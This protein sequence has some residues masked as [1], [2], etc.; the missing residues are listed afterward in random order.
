[1]TS[2]W[3]SDT[4][5]IAEFMGQDTWHMNKAIAAIHSMV[6]SLLHICPLF[7][8]F[9]TGAQE[10]WLMFAE[11]FEDGREIQAMSISE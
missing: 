7:V 2:Y 10:T 11:E 8:C 6:P 3:P 1:M 5:D 4:T 9:L